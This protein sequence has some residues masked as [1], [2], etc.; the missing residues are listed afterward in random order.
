MLKSKDQT[1]AARNTLPNEIAGRYC[2][3]ASH[4]STELQTTSLAFRRKKSFSVPILRQGDAWRR[5][6]SPRVNG[7][8][9]V[10]LQSSCLF[11]LPGLVSEKASRKEV[12]DEALRLSLSLSLDSLSAWVLGYVTQHSLVMQSRRALDPHRNRLHAI[13]TR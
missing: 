13:I 8:F 7:S 4:L 2:T 5:N 9:F 10:D 12:I 6:P 3:E 1:T 11:L